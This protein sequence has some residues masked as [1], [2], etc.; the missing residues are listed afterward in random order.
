MESLY[1]VEAYTN[2][3]TLAK[4]ERV[5]KYANTTV[6]QII[7]WQIIDATLRSDYQVKVHTLPDNKYWVDIVMAGQSSNTNTILNPK[8]RE[9]YGEEGIENICFFD[10]QDLVEESSELDPMFIEPMYK[11][12]LSKHV[13]E[14]GSDNVVGCIEVELYQTL[15]EAKEAITAIL[16]VAKLHKINYFDRDLTEEETTELSTL[17]SKY[18]PDYQ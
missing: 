9:I 11:A 2:G 7:T 6:S 5:A 3:T 8:L 15:H 4:L 10:P 14:Q 17:V 1:K 18:I 12:V 13:L 16:R